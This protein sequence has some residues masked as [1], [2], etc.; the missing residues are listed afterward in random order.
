[1]LSDN[2]V[3]PLLKKEEAKVGYVSTPTTF[4]LTEDTENAH[5]IFTNQNKNI[6]YGMTNI[7]TKG[8]LQEELELH[9]EIG[10]DQTAKITIYNKAM[11]SD[12]KETHEINKLK[13][14]YDLQE[15][16]GM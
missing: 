3:Y 1:M 13:F 11:G 12:Y 9:S 16:E 7:A 4:L 14:Y 6:N 8:F 2:T 10:I 15:I 5:F